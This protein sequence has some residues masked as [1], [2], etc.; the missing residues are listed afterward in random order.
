MSGMLLISSYLLYKTIIFSWLCCYCLPTPLTLVSGGV[1]SSRLWSTSQLLRISGQKFLHS[2]GA[3]SQIRWRQRG[4][5]V[6]AVEDGCTEE[7]YLCRTN[8]HNGDGCDLASTLCK[9]DLRN[10]VCSEL[11]KWATSEAGKY[12][13]RAVNVW[14]RYAQYFVLASCG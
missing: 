11:G 3:C 5:C 14:G 10:T 6:G 12:L 8:G 1:R 9:Y 2:S 7:D 13:F 4:V